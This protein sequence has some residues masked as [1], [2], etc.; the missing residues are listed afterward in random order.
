M[1]AV[2]SL[3]AE[4]V[5]LCKSEIGMFMKLQSVWYLRRVTLPYELGGFDGFISS[6]HNWQ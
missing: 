1:P 4:R 3:T 6:V 5:W 2:N